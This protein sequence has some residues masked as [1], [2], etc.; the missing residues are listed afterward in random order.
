M[1]AIFSF[2]QKTGCEYTGFLS[3]NPS[4]QL[5]LV[6][7]VTGADMLSHFQI[8]AIAKCSLLNISSSGGLLSLTFQL[9]FQLFS[10]HLG[11]IPGGLASSLFLPIF[12]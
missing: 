5:L 10:V 3:S 7:K 12:Y 6:A 11:V 9:V 4:I 8:I 1:E 2:F